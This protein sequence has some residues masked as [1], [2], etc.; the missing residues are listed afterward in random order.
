MLE[1]HLQQQR[2]YT[3]DEEVSTDLRNTQGNVRASEIKKAF[4]SDQND[5]FVDGKF[6]ADEV[7]KSDLAEALNE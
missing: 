7:A 5:F 1:E 6:N 2:L 4:D 3:F